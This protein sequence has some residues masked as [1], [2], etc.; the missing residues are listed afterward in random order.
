MLQQKRKLNVMFYKPPEGDLLLNRMVAYVDPPY[1]HVEV[2]FEDGSA[3]SIFQG[4]TVFVQPRT[5][6]NPNYT[7]VTLSVSAANYNTTL[8][9]C[10]AARKAGVGFH[11]A[12]M[13][14]SLLPVQLVPSR[15][16]ATFCSRYVTELLQ[17]AGVPE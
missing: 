14:A 2:C 1:S 9:H 3:T 5:Y 6:S 10:Q 17:A 15:E 13:Y 16:D 4:E 8:Q 11:S 12:G 7:I